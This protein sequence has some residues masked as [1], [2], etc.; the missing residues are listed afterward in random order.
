MPAAW[1][2]PRAAVVH[3]VP[4]FFF[5]HDV[6]KSDVA[7]FLPRKPAIAIAIAMATALAARKIQ[8]AV[9]GGIA[10]RELIELKQLLDWDAQRSNAQDLKKVTEL[11]VDAPSML[12]WTVSTVALFALYSICAAANTN[13]TVFDVVRADSGIL[14]AALLSGVVLVTASWRLPTPRDTTMISIQ[15][16]IQ[17]FA[18]TWNAV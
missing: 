9:R 14:L 8:A 7:T 6:A 5:D 15:I 17:R 3:R 2:A 4:K 13:A 18:A 12:A 1:R 16:G 11:P 10:R